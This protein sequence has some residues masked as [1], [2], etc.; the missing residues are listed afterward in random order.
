MLSMPYGRCYGL[1]FMIGSA[2]G[3]KLLTLHVPSSSNQCRNERR[4]TCEPG[5]HQVE[6][7]GIEMSW[8]VTQGWAE[9]AR[10]RVP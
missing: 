8:T 7:Q 3:D 4:T 9:A 1:D 6:A 2:G 10:V 5:D